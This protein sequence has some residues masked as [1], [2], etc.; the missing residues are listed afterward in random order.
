MNNYEFSF[1]QIRVN[2]IILKP[3]GF[4]GVESAII[5]LHKNKFT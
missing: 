4:E 1:Y 3:T 2:F 5:D